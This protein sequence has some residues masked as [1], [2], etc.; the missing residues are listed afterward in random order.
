MLVALYTGRPLGSF[1]GKWVSE[2][3][4]SL[5]L[6]IHVG[7]GV[8]VSRMHIGYVLD[9]FPQLAAGEIRELELQGAEITVF[10]GRPPARGALQARDDSGVKAPFLCFS[11]GRAGSAQAVREGLPHLLDRAHG[12][13]LATEQLL[14]SPQ[15]SWRLLRDGVLLAAAAKKRGV[16]RLHARGLEAAVVASFASSALGIPFS[17]VLSEADGACDAALLPLV[18]SAEFVIATSECQ[19]DGLLE[20]LPGDA[21]IDVRVLREGV[22][23][24]HFHPVHRTRSLAGPLVACFEPL[25]AGA[26][27]RELIEAAAVVRR[28]GSDA[29][30]V[31]AGEGPQREELGRHIEATGANVELLGACS[32]AAARE[33]LTAAAVLV[34]PQAA[35]TDGLAEC[36]IRALA[37]G[38]PVVGVRGRRL[39]EILDQGRAGV[40]VPDGTAIELAGALV[41]VLQS[42]PIRLA[43]AREGRKRTEHLH[44]LKVNVGRLRSWFQSAAVPSRAGEMRDYVDLQ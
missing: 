9:G 41:D 24:D 27:I 10:L 5:C 21:R 32:D 31:V 37:A 28:T 34:I 30:F 29:R 44:D 22:D 16:K 15:T 17:F 25:A 38:V 19:R 18:S 42:R 6:A 43:L 12:L 11:S 3:D 26:G 20:G 33:I 36:A 2:V 1:Y 39:T 13:L 8:W 7:M 35:D 23:V 40:L 4:S 14:S